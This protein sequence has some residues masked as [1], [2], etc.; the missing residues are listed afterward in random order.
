MKPTATF[1][2][3]LIATSILLASAPSFANDDVEVIQVTATKA[4]PVDISID[5]DALDKSQAQDLNDIFRKQ[6]EVS[7]GG[8]S[9]VSQKIYVR[10]LE[11]TMLNVSIDGAEQSG[12][13]FHHQG[14]LSIEPELLEK[15]EVNAGAGRATNGPGALG[16]S[17]KFT[18]KNA[19]DLLAADQQF[20]AQ[21]KGGYYSNNKGKKTSASLYGRVADNWGVLTS[22]GYTKGDNLVNGDGEEEKNTAYEQKVALVKLSG[23]LTDTQT[24]SL[25]YDY[26]NDDGTRLIKPHM[27]PVEFKNKNVPIKQETDRQTITANHKWTHSSK[28]NL[29][30]TLYTTASK[31]AHIDNPSYGTSDGTITT[32][33]GKVFNTANFA[34]NTLITGV[35]YKKDQLR[36]ATGGKDH[37]EDG[38]VYG[39]FVQDDW[40]VT[41][42]LLLSAGAR[43][44][45][46]KLDEDGHSS[47]SSSGFS[48]NVS[49]SYF[50]LPEIKVHASIAQAFRGQQTK[51][52]FLVGWAVN[53]A[54]RVAE[55]ATN[56]EIGVNYS[57]Q[58]FSAG[59]TLFDNKIEN[60][61]G[62]T[63]IN[64]KTVMANLGELRTKGVTGYAGY[65]FDRVSTHLSYNQSRPELNGS[66]LLDYHFNLGTS[67]GDTWV[68][69]VNYQHN[70]RLAFGWNS[71]FVE[72]LTHVAA[73]ESEK[74]AYDV[75]DVY[76]RWLPM[77]GEDLALTLSIKNLFDNYYKDHASWY[78]YGY[79]QAGRDVRLNASWAF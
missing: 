11:D 77:A 14:R 42:A 3:S 71:R 60:V 22:F 26:R 63:K 52:M 57:K 68:L 49:A 36:F 44:D 69:D 5:S 73:G 8:S 75:H 17:I 9:G 2:L 20:G 30:T 23:D 16:G 66:P 40:Q 6:S 56:K 45:W 39:V 4:Q 1:N 59:I 33:G 21:V 37:T 24:L 72:K 12:S 32:N 70:D 51:E 48:P 13:L 34:N 65:E 35:D 10:G 7:V 76:A 74:D 54:N 78:D 18:T 25:S 46:Y 15:V 55:E 50:I 28:L 19:D 41:Q 64:G 27:Q 67:I 53:D 43:Y 79:A 62:K 61:V 38:T 58:S 31:L 29:D 47:F